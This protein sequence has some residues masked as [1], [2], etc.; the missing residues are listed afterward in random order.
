MN[1]FKTIVIK[2]KKE[3]PTLIP[4]IENRY[5]DADWQIMC[6]SYNG[7]EIGISPVGEAYYLDTGKV[8]KGSFIELSPVTMTPSEFEYNLNL[9]LQELIEPFIEKEKAFQDDILCRK[10]SKEVPG[11]YGD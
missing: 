11:I 3:Y 8:F 7:I 1:K 2:L 9:E 6:W 5:N 10:L 4:H